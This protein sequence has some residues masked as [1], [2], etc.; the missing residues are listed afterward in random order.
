METPTNGLVNGPM[1][2]ISIQN[3]KEF[4]RHTFRHSN[5]KKISEGTRKKLQL[6]KESDGEFYMSF[7]RD[8]VR[9]FGEVEVVHIG[10]NSMDDDDIDQKYDVFPFRGSWKGDSAG[11][12]GNDGIRKFCP[13]GSNQSQFFKI[14]LQ[15]TLSSYSRFMIQTKQMR[16]MS[17]R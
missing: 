8:F 4:H 13:K 12:C 11:G 9:Y 2:K 3:Y 10:P 16:P 17:A 15:R 6:T 1:G 7:N 14:T 5:W